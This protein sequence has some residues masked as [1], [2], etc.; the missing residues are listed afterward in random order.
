VQRLTVAVRQAGGK[1]TPARSWIETG[2]EEALAAERR[3]LA[4][5]V[6]AVGLLTE[7]E[8]RE[9]LA[10]LI[11]GAAADESALLTR[12]GHRPLPSAFPGQPPR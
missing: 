12:L 2:L 6:Q 1:L 9:L 11:A 3:A 10:G 7:R 8:H 4:S 5:Y